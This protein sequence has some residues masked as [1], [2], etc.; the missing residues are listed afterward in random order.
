MLIQWR[1]CRLKSLRSSRFI[2]ALAG[3]SRPSGN[4]ARS[5]WAIKV[6]GCGFMSF[7]LSGAARMVRDQ[8]AIGK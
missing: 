7:E 2:H 4:P 1:G 6:S 5:A 3:I 8:A